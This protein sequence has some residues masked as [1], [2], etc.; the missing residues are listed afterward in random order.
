MTAF[1][2]ALC[3]VDGTPESLA[4]VGTAAE[5]V[6]PDGHLTLLIVTSF[7]HL[8]EVHFPAIPPGRASEIIAQAL[9]VTESAG[10]STTVDVDPAGPPAQV[11]LQWAADRDLLAIGAPAPSWFGAMLSGGVAAAAE[12]SLSTPLLVY[13]LTAGV[14]SPP[15]ILVASDGR[16]ESDGLVELAG[17]LAEAE[18]AGVTLL[19]ALG[20]AS[21]AYL[22]RIHREANRLVLD[23]IQRQANRLALLT[24]RECDL[25]IVVGDARSLVVDTAHEV[26]ASLI[27]MSSRRLQGLRTVG[28][29]SRRVVHQAGCPV[30]LLPPEYLLARTAS[31]ARRT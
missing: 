10:V 5:L 11:I 22:P 16:D 24:G 15:R 2:S 3:A 13:H 21:H 31:A 1:A 29:V 8:P 6:G 12:A 9:Q 7:R 30:L 17:E 25:R 26:A 14:A 18:G 28:S 27:V 4:A 20:P 19:H 23:R